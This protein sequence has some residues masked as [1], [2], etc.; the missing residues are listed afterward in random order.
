MNSEQLAAFVQVAETENVTEAAAALKLSQ[1]TVSRMIARLEAELGSTL[2]DRAGHTVR[3][4]RKGTDFLPHARAA[5]AAMQGGAESVR[6]LDD[7]DR[8]R[9]RIGFLH[10]LGVWLV[11]ELLRDF[12]AG[13][14]A[15]TFDLFQGAA[16]TTL[17][18]LLHGELDV[19]FTGPKPEDPALNWQALYR[20]QLVV[21]VPPNHPLTDL[22]RPVTLADVVDHPYLAMTP[23]HGMRRL[24]DALLGQ[25]GLEPDIAFEGSDIE[26][27]RGL[28]AAGLGVAIVPRAHR[29]QPSTA[30]ELP[31]DGPGAYRDVGIAWTPLSGS[32]PVAHRFRRFAVEHQ[33]R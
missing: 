11:P 21:A 20:Q 22:D 26:T 14:P 15:V 1:P 29:L 19:A 30:V 32:S 2:F 18:K 24:T 27:L 23:G 6:S 4:N 8:G 16:R 31:L 3:L 12:R 28:A 13:A 25:A 10:S 9:L 7:A 17:D 33:I 5:L